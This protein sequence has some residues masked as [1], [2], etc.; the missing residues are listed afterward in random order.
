[1]RFWTKQQR[2]GAYLTTYGVGTLVILLTWHKSEWR[3]AI[4][5]LTALVFGYIMGALQFS[6]SE[7]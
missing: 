7:N 6:K 2:L 4:Q 1:M 5:F 3:E